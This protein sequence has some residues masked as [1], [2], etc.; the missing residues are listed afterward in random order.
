MNYAE[1][2][3]VNQ[4][5]NHDCSHAIQRHCNHLYIHHDD[6]HFGTS[7]HTHLVQSHITRVKFTVLY[8][9]GHNTTPMSKTTFIILS[10]LTRQRNL[11]C[12]STR[13][14]S[15]SQCYLQVNNI[16]DPQWTLLL[17][18]RLLLYRPPLDPPRKPLTRPRNP[19]WFPLDKSW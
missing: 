9:T 6:S 7:V 2:T 19:H 5:T 11:A 3:Q 16:C 17:P 4:N 12:N 14:F 13:M 1:R 18:P 8:C 15:I 10:V